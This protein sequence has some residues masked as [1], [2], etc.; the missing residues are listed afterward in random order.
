[1]PRFHDKQ[2]YDILCGGPLW[3]LLSDNNP[4]DST[5]MRLFA[6]AKKKP[7]RRADSVCGRRDIPDTTGTICH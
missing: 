7:R 4:I 2:A 5:P 1:L 3:G 6:D